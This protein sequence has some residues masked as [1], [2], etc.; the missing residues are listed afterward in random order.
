MPSATE[1]AVDT[2]IRI[3]S[4]RDPDARARMIEACWAL[5]GRLVAHGGGVLRGR[6]A[7]L[8]MFARVAADP[9]ISRVRVLARDVRGTTFRFRYATDRIDGTSTEG[10]DAGEVDGAGRISILLAFTGPLVDG[11]GLER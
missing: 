5:D 8:A 9:S 2:Y 1:Q 7:M 11:A 4:E 3:A 10:F 6:D